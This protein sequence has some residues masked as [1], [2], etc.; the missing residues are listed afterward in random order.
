M[1]ALP[2]KTDFIS[3]FEFS[4]LCFLAFSVPF[5]NHALRNFK[6]E[7]SNNLLRF[8]I[9]FLFSLRRFL[10]YLLSLLLISSDTRSFLQRIFFISSLVCYTFVCCPC[11]IEP[12]KCSSVLLPILNPMLLFYDFNSHGRNDTAF[13]L[14]FAVYFML[15]FELP[16]TA[17]IAS[18]HVFQPGKMRLYLYALSAD[19][20]GGYPQY[21]FC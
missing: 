17:G 7:I 8:C 13:D 19:S 1:S 4:F 12:G 10:L 21:G 5:S 18:L 20:R 2:K 3:R 9:Y 11:K 14:A 6:E 15:H 16:V